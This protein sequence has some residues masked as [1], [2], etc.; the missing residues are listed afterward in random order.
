VDEFDNSLK[1]K[2]CIYPITVA[3]YGKHHSSKDLEQDGD[4]YKSLSDSILK[5]CTVPISASNYVENDGN[6]YCY[7]S[8]TED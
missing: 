7:T 3:D 2:N 8:R 5:Y 4:H 6:H 1:N